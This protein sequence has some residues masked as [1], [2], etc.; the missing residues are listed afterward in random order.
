MSKSFF[1]FCGGTNESLLCG[2]QFMINPTEGA[3]GHSRE[4]KSH[5]LGSVVGH[6]HLKKNN[7]APAEPEGLTK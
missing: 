2:K 3:V 4:V 6:V 5:Q 1:A 7:G